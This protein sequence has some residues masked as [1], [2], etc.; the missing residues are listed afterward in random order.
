MNLGYVF[1]NYITSTTTKLRLMSHNETTLNLPQRNYHK[2]STRN[3]ATVPTTRD[4]FNKV[5]TIMTQ[6]HFVL[7]TT[8]F[9]LQFFTVCTRYTVVGGI[10][11]TTFYI[12]LF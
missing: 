2:V 7:S 8:I 11:L 4:S 9:Q 1:Q 5:T 6:A 3:Y 10:Y 12:D